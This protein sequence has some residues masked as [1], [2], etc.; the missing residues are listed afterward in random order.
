MTKQRQYAFIEMQYIVTHS[1][2]RDGLLF[3][4]FLFTSRSKAAVAL[5]CTGSCTR[6]QSSVLDQSLF[7]VLLSVPGNRNRRSLKM[8]LKSDKYSVMCC[9]QSRTVLVSLS[10]WCFL[11]LPGNYHGCAG[12]EDR[13]TSFKSVCSHILSLKSV[14]QWLFSALLL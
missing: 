12:T 3:K 11:F 13:I 9:K 14:T 8:K 5:S 10:N 2:N 1:R 4:M 6:W 7:F